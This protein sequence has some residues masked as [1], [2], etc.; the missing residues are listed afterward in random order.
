MLEALAFCIAVYDSASLHLSFYRPLKP[1]MQAYDNAEGVLA[2][3]LWDEAGEDQQSTLIA[4]QDGYRRAV[5]LSGEQLLDEIAAC[6]K[7]FGSVE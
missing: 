7:R 3:R 2:G 5:G 1:E 4:M 6:E